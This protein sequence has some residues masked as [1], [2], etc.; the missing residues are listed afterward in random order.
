MSAPAA[1]AKLERLRAEFGGDHARTKLGLLRVLS[2]A[3]LSTAGQALRLHDVLLFLRAYPDDRAV[4]VMVDRMR[5]RCARR[6][7]FVR[8]RAT[9]ENSG[10]AGTTTRFR[11]F[12]P[13]AVWLARQW[14]R[15]LTIDWSELES[16]ELLEAMLPLLAHPA[17]S[18]ALD[19][20][21]LPLREWIARMKSPREADGAFLACRFAEL[22]MAD[23]A[24]EILYDRIDAPLVL[25]PARGT[26]SR[27]HAV[28]PQRTI[29][30][31]TAPLT[32]TRPD[33]RREALRPPIA[34]REPGPRECQALIDLARV[35]MVTRQRDLDAF[36]H[37]SAQD[38]RVIE[39]PDGLSFVAIGVRPARR[40][41]LEAVYGFLTLKNGVPIGYVLASALFGSA[42]IAYNVFETWRGVEAAA[43]YGR[44]VSMLRHLFG[45]D[46]FTIYPYQLGEGNDE[47]LDT[48]AWWFYRKLGFE[49]RDRATRALMRVEERRMRRNP[50]ARSSRGTLARLAC[51]NLYWSLG[52]TRDDIIGRIE[53]TN[54]GLHV[55]RLLARR[56]GSD[57]E[58]TCDV[59]APEMERLLGV[60]SF[61]GWSAGERDAFH[62]WAPLIAIL[63]G[64]ARWTRAERTALVA[65]ARAKGGRRESDFVARFDA[66][67]KL[68]RAI[69]ALAARE[70]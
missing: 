58:H 7:D 55:M 44:V 11:F 65:V 16:S 28:H 14:P 46:H 68:R 3:P 19:E 38:V 47:A 62:R 13:T 24:R 30:Y 35:S 63:P 69:V 12:E 42:E 54:V 45:A 36:A 59:I 53:T 4:Q 29:A 34:V 50:A 25:V 32:R 15:S 43:V 27:T 6:A 52:G 64:V 8:H 2:R 57:R 61:A 26:P 33:L 37:G 23:S 67:P 49:P 18:A 20:L 56:L 10:I 66:H 9:L 22:S 40:L 48:G 41:L 39:Y 17:E 1:L 60:R 31:Q 21:D 51:E 70:P 5:A